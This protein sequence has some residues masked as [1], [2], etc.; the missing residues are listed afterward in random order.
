MLSTTMT[1]GVLPLG[2]KIEHHIWYIRTQG[3]DDSTIASITSW[4]YKSS[5]SLI[6]S[7]DCSVFFGEF[8]DGELVRLLPKCSHAFHLPCIDKWLK[9]HG[10]C[11]LCRAPIVSPATATVL[12]PS[13]ASL[14]NRRHLKSSRPSN[15]LPCSTQ[16]LT[17]RGL[18]I[19]KR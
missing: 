4:I 8:Y 12:A 2:G 1:G 6:D 16:N 3:L 9:S 10:N 15:W 18:A 19:G 17:N 13:P 11:P 5:D 14:A 7:K